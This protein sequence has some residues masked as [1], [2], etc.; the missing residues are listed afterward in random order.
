[1]AVLRNPLLT[2]LVHCEGAD[3]LQVSQLEEGVQGSQVPLT[4]AKPGSQTVQ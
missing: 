4:L 3:A 1:M 2:Q